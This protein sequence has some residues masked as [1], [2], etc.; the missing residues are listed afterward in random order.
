MVDLGLRLDTLPADRDPIRGTTTSVFVPDGPHGRATPFFLL[1]GFG[2]DGRSYSALTP[3]AESRRVVFWNPPNELPESGGLDAI[4]DLALAHAELAGCGGPVILGGASLGGVVALNAALR[5]P[6]RVAGLVLF[7]VPP[8]W[9]DVGFVVRLAAAF[10]GLTPRRRYHRIL[11]KVLIPSAMELPGGTALHADLRAQMARR[12]RSY[13][14]RL[15]GAVRGEN[16]AIRGR[17][18]EMAPPALVIQGALDRVVPPRA[19]RTLARMPSS[20]VI[21]LDS[22]M[23]APFA[24]HARSCLQALDPFLSEVDA[25]ARGLPR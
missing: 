15:L 13:G 5:H 14:T 22:A 8:G 2:L 24:T 21:V 25:Y 11:P 12:T 17:L 1:P 7:G 23:H 3:L 19:A 4:A 9:S 18:G 20:R 10:H 16:G 6:R